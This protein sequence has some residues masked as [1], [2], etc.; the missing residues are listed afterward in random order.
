MALSLANA[1]RTTR[2]SGILLKSPDAADAAGMGLRLDVYRTLVTIQDSRRTITAA[3]APNTM[4]IVTAA[5]RGLEERVMASPSFRGRDR[6]N[7]S[8]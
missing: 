6:A 5:P 7:R 4:A 3:A 8:V 2:G 1:R